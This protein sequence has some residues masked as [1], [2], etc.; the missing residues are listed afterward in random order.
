MSGNPEGDIRSDWV[1]YE[2]AGATGPHDLITSIRP[3]LDA[4][5][6]SQ[7]IIDLA[8]RSSIEP[9]RHPELVAQ[10]VVLRSALRERLEH[11]NLSSLVVPF[12]PGTYNP[13]ATIGEN[14]RFGTAKGPA[15]GDKALATNP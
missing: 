5:M 15:L 9:E 2:A 3:V 13:E 7:D 10:I 4:T 14:L 11:E 6:L 8:L 1:D 12:E